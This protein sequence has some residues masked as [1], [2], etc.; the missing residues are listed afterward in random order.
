MS[1]GMKP[2][3]GNPLDEELPVNESDEETE[4]STE[5]EDEDTQPQTKLNES[6]QSPGPD[7][8]PAED[9]TRDDLP[10]LLTRTT[11]KDGRKSVTYF[12]RPETRDLEKQVRRAVEE[13]LKTDVKK[14]DIRE[15]LVCVGANHVDEVA[16]LLRDAGYRYK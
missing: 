6:S 11:A 10:Y 12:L 16:E 5:A 2:G 7:E 13:E 4:T 15:A 3:T 9:I 1:N 8:P 14:L